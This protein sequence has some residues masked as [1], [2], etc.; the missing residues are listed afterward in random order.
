MPVYETLPGWREEL[1]G[2]PRR[3]GLPENARRYVE[4]IGELLGRP[5]A[6]VSVGPDRDQTIFCDPPPTATTTMAT[7]PA[8]APANA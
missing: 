7:T 8:P 1:T 2:R 6:I 5:V 4:R 3:G